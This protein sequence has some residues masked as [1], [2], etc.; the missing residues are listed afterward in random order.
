MATREEMLALAEA[1][2]FRWT[3]EA[4]L[5]RYGHQQQLPEEWLAGRGTEATFQLSA[6]RGMK[7]RCRGSVR[8]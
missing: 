1:D 8:A 2:D 3:D 6:F 5:A 7:L 4:D